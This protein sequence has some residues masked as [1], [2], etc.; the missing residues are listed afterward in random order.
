M[1][2]PE[3]GDFQGLP[4][5]RRFAAEV[6]GWPEAAEDW[7]WCARFLYQVIERRGTGGGNFRLMYSRFLEE[8]G[9]EESALAAAAAASWTSLASAAQAA[10]EPEQPDPRCGRPSPMKPR[11]C[12]R[13]RSACGALSPPERSVACLVHR[14]W[15]SELRELRHL[16]RLAG[17]GAEGQNADARRRRARACAS[18]RRSL[19]PSCPGRA[20]GARPRSRFH[21][22]RGAPDRPP[23]D[24]PRSGRAPGGRRSRPGCRSRRCR[25]R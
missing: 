22:S 23:P 2:E 11:P 12:W 3:L 16:V 20:D 13:P 8:A 21:R 4:A 24:R 25:T 19:A 9:Y 18:C 1:L 5:L 10:S 15:S 6:G 7:R 14:V 17:D